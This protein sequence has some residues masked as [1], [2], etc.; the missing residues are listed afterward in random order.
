MK[1]LCQ[2]DAE[3]HHFVPLQPSP[4]SR[5]RLNH[6]AQPGWDEIKRLID[7]LNVR[8][9]EHSRKAVVGGSCRL[10]VIIS[11]SFAVPEVRC[12][13]D[14][15]RIFLSCDRIAASPSGGAATNRS[16]IYLLGNAECVIHFY[17]EIA[18]GALKLRMPQQELNSTQVARLFVNLRGL[19]SAHRMSAVL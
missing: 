3:H 1:H 7:S 14:N 11:G 6:Q 18:D 15:G 10:R 2:I 13:H 8:F 19:R 17:S 4:G 12:L 5:P 16:E 9:Q